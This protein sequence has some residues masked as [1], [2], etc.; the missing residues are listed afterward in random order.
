MFLAKVS[1]NLSKN[2]RFWNINPFGWLKSIVKKLN[3]LLHAVY[4]DADFVIK[5][6]TVA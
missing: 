2:N 3:E 5:E 1:L 4:P 6:S